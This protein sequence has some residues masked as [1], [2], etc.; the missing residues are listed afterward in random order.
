MDYDLDFVPSPILIK[1]LQSRHDEMILLGA[2]KRTGEVEDL[3]V[4]YSGSY[5][6]CV[7]LL[8]IGKLAI[9]TQGDSKDD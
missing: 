6:A 4:S 7:G 3:T 1:E 2:T 9:T 8:E 5:H